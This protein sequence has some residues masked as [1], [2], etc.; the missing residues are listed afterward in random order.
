MEISFLHLALLLGFSTGFHCVGMCG[1]IAISLG[2]SSGNKLKYILKNLVYQSG[3]IFTYSLLGLAVGI[4]G[5]GFS[6]SGYHQQISIGLGALMMLMAISNFLSNQ[7]PKV[8]FLDNIL[9]FVKKEL[10]KLLAQKNKRSLFYIGLL[11]GFLPCGAV[12]GALTVAVGLQ[13]IGKSVLF[14]AFFGL[15]TLP[16]MFVMVYL[17]RFIGLNFREKLTKIAPILVFFIGLLFVVRGSGLE[18]PYLSPASSALDLFPKE[19]CCH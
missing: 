7:M 10:G 14:M 16:F 8:A 4:I 11:N 15:G 17:G 5:K 19:S 6:L 1:P 12:Y 9:S 3:R 18:I 2:I 13:E